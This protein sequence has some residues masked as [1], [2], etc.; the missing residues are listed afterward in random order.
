MAANP[1]SEKD[2]GPGRFLSSGL[3]LAVGI[4]LGAAIGA[5]IDKKHPASNPWGL[6]VGCCLGFFAA[7]YQ[8]I[9]NAIKSNR[10]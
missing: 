7:M 5:W 10:D 8:L 6:V 2:P 9:K 4:G 1:G 3:E